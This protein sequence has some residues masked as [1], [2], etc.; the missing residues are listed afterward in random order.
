M[1]WKW[2][3][4]LFLFIT[5]QGFC[6]TCFGESD[7]ESSY[8]KSGFVAVIE[9]LDSDYEIFLD[10]LKAK[11]FFGVDVDLTS[12]QTKRWFQRQFG[13]YT[14]RVNS[15]YKGD[16]KSD[17]LK[18]YTGVGGGDCGF[19]FK[20]DEKYVVYGRAWEEADPYIKSTNENYIWTDICTR[21]MIYNKMEEKRLQKLVE[22][23]KRKN[24]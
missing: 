11:E 18:I 21:T 23:S 8:K 20:L 9:V 1:R 17:T 6:C 10:T 12:T 15:L 4:G 3:L 16:L 7:T 2:I 22:K 5:E 13:N 19:K 14:V 24:K